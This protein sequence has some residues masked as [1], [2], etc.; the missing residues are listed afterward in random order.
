MNLMM[1]LA[2]CTLCARV[3]VLTPTYMT[4]LVACTA[5]AWRDHT[6]W[7]LIDGKAPPDT[8]FSGRGRVI[9]LSSPNTSNWKEFVKGGCVC[10]S[11][12]HVVRLCLL[13][14]HLYCCVAAIVRALLALG[15]AL[16]YTDAM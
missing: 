2:H 16:Q 10:G 12:L 8:Q 11:P 14:R 7:R 1:C 6:V 5:A 4:F 9:V 13:C 3:H 15:M